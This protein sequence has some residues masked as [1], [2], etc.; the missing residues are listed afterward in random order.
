MDG[1]QMCAI[2][3]V[4]WC[5]RGLCVSAFSVCHVGARLC[6]CVHGRVCRFLFKS[7]RG[8]FVGS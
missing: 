6:E 2:V 1:C 3:C 5:F 8:T 7:E 4:R